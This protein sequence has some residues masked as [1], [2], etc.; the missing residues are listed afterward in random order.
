MSSGRRPGPHGE[1]AAGPPWIFGLRGSPREAP[2]NTLA[3]LRRAVE[4]GLAGVAYDVRACA[5]GELVLLAD[6]TLDRT[7]DAT[8]PLAS[9]DVRE[10]SGIDAGAWFGPRFAGAPL[11]WL[12]EALELEGNA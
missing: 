1:L 6:P 5:S 12:D 10:L 9:R 4:M 11:A 2:E 3:S 7:T 8:G